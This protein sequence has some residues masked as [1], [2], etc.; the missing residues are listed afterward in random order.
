MGKARQCKRILGLQGTEKHLFAD[1]KACGFGI[2][3]T[4]IHQYFYFFFSHGIKG[5]YR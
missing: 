4:A 5:N 2:F 3:K 1:L